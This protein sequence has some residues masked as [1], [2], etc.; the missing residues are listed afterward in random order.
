MAMQTNQGKADYQRSLQQTATIRVLAEAEKAACIGI[1]QAIAIE[2]LVRAYGG[3][4]F[5][6]L[7]RSAIA[8]P[9]RPHP[10]DA[11]APGRRAAQQGAAS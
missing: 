4:Q 8:S 2:E 6:I 3:L 7:T 9:D 5:P 11:A 10:A 1:A